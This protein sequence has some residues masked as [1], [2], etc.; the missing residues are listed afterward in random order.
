MNLLEIFYYIKPVI[1]RGLQILARQT[2]AAYKRNA[3]KHIW[4]INSSATALPIGWNGWPNQNRFAL[5]L[6]HDVDTVRGLDRCIQLMEIEK[7]LGFI[8]TFNFVAEDYK[9]PISLLQELKESG[10]DVGLHGLRHNGKLFS[11]RNIF[12]LSIPRINYYLRKWGAVGF[13]SPSMHRNLDWISELDIEYSSSTFDTDP[14]EPQPDGVNTIFPIWITNSSRT[15]GYIE[16]PYTLP[17]D[18]CLFVILK[19]TDIKVWN[20]KLKWLAENCGMAFLNTHPDYMNFSGRRNSLEEYPVNY[21]RDF[22]EHIQNEYKGQYWHV[23]PKGLARF[24]SSMLIESQVSPANLEGK[25]SV[26]FSEGPSKPSRHPLSTSGAK[27]WIDLDNTPHVPFFIPIIRELERKGHHII[28]TARDAFQVCE[29]ADEK[30]LS[31]IKIGRHYGKHAIFKILGLLW[32]SAQLAT[33]FLPHRPDLALSH[34]SRSQTLYCNLRRIPTAIIA[35]YEYAQ[36]IPFAHPR[37]SIVPESVS[38][39]S[40]SSNTNRILHYRGIKEDVYIP[41]FTLNPLL[42]EILGLSLDEMIVTIRPPA[43]EAHYHNPESIPLLMELMK[44]IGQ[45][46]SI[47]AVLLP[48]NQQQEIAFRAEYPAWFADRKVV[49]P[50]KVVDGLSLLWFSDL[51]VSGGGTMNRE[52]AA[53]GVPVYSIFRGKMGAVDRM[54]VREGRLIMITSKEEVHSK[55]HFVKRDKTLALDNHPRPAL[56]DII[57]HIENI[58]RIEQGRT[59]PP[60]RRRPVI[61]R[62][63]SEIKA[64]K[65]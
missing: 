17:Q 10:F 28:L 27:I 9:V 43:D 53:L 39:L 54:L 30:S 4:P 61:N 51:V 6:S 64:H 3:S 11:S 16:L 12:D 40:F 8:S 58:I 59:K 52:A 18:H 14:F 24:W 29:L 23:Q 63:L 60:K 20:Q 44:R 37:W 32:R 15:R 33:F 57:G 45:T 56:Q 13:H 50:P 35:D 49:V 47:R 2:I 36:T 22:L 55:I 5:V 19:E 7:D 34:G 62:E 38:A 31:Y 48:R 65:Q 42:N 46:Q 21:Y 26:P 41:E 1:P 25:T